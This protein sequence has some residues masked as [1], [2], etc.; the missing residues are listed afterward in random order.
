MLIFLKIRCIIVLYPILQSRKLRKKFSEDKNGKNCKKHIWKNGAIHIT[1]GKFPLHLC[2]EEN[3]LW[4]LQ[5][6]I[7]SIHLNECCGGITWS[8]S[9]LKC[10]RDDLEKILFRR[11]MPPDPLRLPRLKLSSGYATVIMRITLKIINHFSFSHTKVCIL[12]FFTKQLP[13]VRGCDL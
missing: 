8:K 4:K 11:S 3:S 9:P 5:L 6:R 7:F 1:V 10:T 2:I 12:I 13:V